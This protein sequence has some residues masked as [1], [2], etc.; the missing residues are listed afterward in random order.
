M[1]RIRD[2]LARAMILGAAAASPVAALAAPEERQRRKEYIKPYLRRLRA[3]ER[4]NFRF[5][6]SS[7]GR[8]ELY[9]LAAD[10]GE[11][12]NLYHP[13]RRTAAADEFLGLLTQELE[14]YV[15]GLGSEVRSAPD[16]AG[17]QAPAEVDDETLRALRAVGYVR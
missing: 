1:K 2:M 8:H 7:N 14:S 10:P 11:T 16:P 4:Y 9:D 15:P 12:R 3:I 6:W 13:E 5:I 17:D